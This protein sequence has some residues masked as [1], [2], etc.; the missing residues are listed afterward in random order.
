VLI[1]FLT[2]AQA[3]ESIGHVEPLRVIT[4]EIGFGAAAGAAAGAL[5]AWVLRTFGRRG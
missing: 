1:T 3:E 2:I 4:E 5:G